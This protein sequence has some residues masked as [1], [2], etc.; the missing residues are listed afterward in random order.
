MAKG[1]YEHRDALLLDGA[2]PRDMSDTAVQ[3][4]DISR[5]EQIRVPRGAES[6]FRGVVSSE[7]L[8]VC[9]SF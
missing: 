2:E 8:V 7:R 3:V 6:S 4:S 1:V 9:L 5:G